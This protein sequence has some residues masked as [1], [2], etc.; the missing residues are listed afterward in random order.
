MR[1]LFHFAAILSLLRRNFA[2]ILPPFCHYFAVAS[3]LYDKDNDK[4]IDVVEACVSFFKSYTQTFV[5]F[6][7]LTELSAL[8]NLNFKCYSGV[9]GGVIR[10]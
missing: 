5:L 4:N 6:L 2:V 1:T 9:M 10:A 8:C 7:I 3:P